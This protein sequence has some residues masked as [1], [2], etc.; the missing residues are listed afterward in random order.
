[1]SIIKI[2]KLKCLIASQAKHNL[3]LMFYILLLLLP[4][5][6]SFADFSDFKLFRLRILQTK[7]ILMITETGIF[8]YNQNMEKQS[9]LI[10]L[11]NIISNENDFYYVTASQFTNLDNNIILSF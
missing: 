9:T 2:K 11:K 5:S 6:I 10:D 4:L 3:S 8:I 1:M 7:K